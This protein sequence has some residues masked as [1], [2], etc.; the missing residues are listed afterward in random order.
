MAE[1]PWVIIQ[2]VRPAQ[3]IRS[4]DEARTTLIGQFV[5]VDVETV[6]SIRYVAP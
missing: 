1:C 2:V 5:E 6:R 4:A 3:V